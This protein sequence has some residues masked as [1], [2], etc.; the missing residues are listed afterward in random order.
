MQSQQNI[1]KVRAKDDCDT[2]IVKTAL[3]IARTDHVEVFLEDTDV[4]VMLVHHSSAVSK[5]MYFTTN[6]VT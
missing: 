6:S 5:Q 1:D 3:K 2:F 4:I